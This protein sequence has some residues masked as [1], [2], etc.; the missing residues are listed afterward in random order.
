MTQQER[1]QRWWEEWS[2]SLSQFWMHLNH[3]TYRTQSSPVPVSSSLSS[4]TSLFTWTINL[5]KNI[6]ASC[7]LRIIS[8]ILWNKVKAEW[9]L[10]LLPQQIDKSIPVLEHGGTFIWKQLLNSNSN[11]CCCNNDGF[12]DIKAKVLQWITLIWMLVVLQ[13]VGNL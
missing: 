5:N 3:S 8:I 7:C 1:V 12:V 4:N 9:K 11:S 10:D 13:E 2:G 6:M